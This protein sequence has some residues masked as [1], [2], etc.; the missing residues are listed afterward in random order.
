MDEL[1]HELLGD[2]LGCTRQFPDRAALS[3]VCGARQGTQTWRQVLIEDISQSGFR[4]ADASGLNLEAA[5]S[6]RLP[7]LHALDARVRW[8]E[9]LGAGCE[10][11]QPLHVAVFDHL[12]REARS[13]AQD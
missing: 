3:L 2:D 8:I 9:A 13:Q 1:P 12:V 5:L 4:I 7:G 6:I 10:F 11:A